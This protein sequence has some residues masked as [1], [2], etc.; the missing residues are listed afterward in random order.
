M[1]VIWDVCDI[2]Y[3]GQTSNVRS[4]MNGH[5]SDYRGFLNGNF[6]KSE[7]SALC[8]HLK[9]H[10]VEMLKFNILEVHDMKLSI[11]IKIFAN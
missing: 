1:Y 6:Y 8:S 9:S 2:R 4:Q 5:K 7:S 11:T 3:V 10:D